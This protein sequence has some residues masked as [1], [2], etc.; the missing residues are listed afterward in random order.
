MN[1]VGD[2]LNAGDNVDD[3]EDYGLRSSFFKINPTL[4]DDYT[5][6]KFLNMQ[7]EHLRPQINIDNLEKHY[8]ERHQINMI[9]DKESDERDHIGENKE[10]TLNTDIEVLKLQ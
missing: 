10:E 7:L 4:I 8:D 3:Q 5:R 1:L 9:D 6:K 2:I